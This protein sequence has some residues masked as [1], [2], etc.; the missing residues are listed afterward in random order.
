MIKLIASDLDG[1]LLRDGAMQVSARAIQLIEQLQKK[2]I[3][4]V[5]ASGR[6]YSNL[7]K[8][9]GNASKEMG[10]LCENGALVMYQ[11]QILYKSAMEHNLAM[12]L[13]HTIY[14]KDDCEVLASGQ[15]TSYLLPKSEEYRHRIQHIVQNNVAIVERFEDIPEDLIKISVYEKAGIEDHSG[16][17]LINLFKE[18]A[19]CTISGFHWLDF[20]NPDVNKGV[21][22]SRLLSHL[23]ISPSETMAFGDNYND[24][25]MLSFVGFGYAMQHAA[26][27]IKKHCSYECS[28]VEDTLE[29]LLHSLE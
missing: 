5:A 3:I 4:F 21:A 12:E 26:D 29:F 28:L 11:D 9:F 16:P 7:Y 23:S 8:L 2:G 24:L 10:F 27:P 22:L 18:S 6:Q 20:V 15:D 13:C 1:T 25:E 14:N 17:Y 19:K